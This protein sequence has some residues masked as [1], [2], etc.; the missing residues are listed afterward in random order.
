M[1]IPRLSKTSDLDTV[2]G[3][4]VKAVQSLGYRYPTKEQLEVAEKFVSGRDVFVSLPTGSGKSVCYACL[5]LV[6]DMLRDQRVHPSIVVVIAPLSAL[7]QD[8]VDSF[9]ARGLKSACIGLSVDSSASDDA[10]V[11][12]EA[13]LVF[14]SPETLL[15]DST[16]RD[17]L[18]TRIYQENLVALAIDEAHLV[19]KWSVMY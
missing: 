12:G 10:V 17:M 7:M 5:P 15:S 13:Q 2:R 8:Q 18:R 4:I 9:N 3:S 16:W 11:R 19:E 14:T 1:V 6:F